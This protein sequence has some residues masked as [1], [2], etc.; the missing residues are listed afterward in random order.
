MKRTCR[1]RRLTMCRKGFCRNFSLAVFRSLVYIRRLHSRAGTA[2]P[3]YNRKVSPLP[4]LELYG[5]LPTSASSTGQR[6]IKKTAI[7]MKLI[8]Y[9]GHRFGK[10]F[11][12]NRVSSKTPGAVRWLCHCDCGNDKEVD[13]GHLRNGGVRS[14]GCIRASRMGLCRT[15]E[16]RA[17]E[18]MF[19]RCKSTNKDHDFKWYGA[20][21]I[22][23]CARWKSSFQSF[24][25][26]MGPRPLNKTSLD[27]IDPKKGY[28]PE[29]CRWATAKEQ[30]RNKN[31]N[32]LISYDGREQCIAAWEEERGFVKNT[33]WNRLNHGWDVKRAIETPVRKSKPRRKNNEADCAV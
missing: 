26:D 22:S 16:G 5:F 8:D 4:V 25:D 11:V 27:R 13:S 9:T 23:V 1:A 14:C 19:T 20:N 7:A 24:L 15:P 21:N 3:A 10:L 32:V 6:R 12:L 33:I 29:N 31:N 28:F 30:A 18:G 2:K 17:Y